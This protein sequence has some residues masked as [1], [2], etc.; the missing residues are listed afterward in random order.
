MK[1]RQKDLRAAI[2]SGVALPLSE[3]RKLVEANRDKMRDFRQISYSIGVYGI[4]GL[5]IEDTTTGQLYA[6]AARTSN[7]FMFHRF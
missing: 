1:V 4:N 2:N 7:V 6:D 5:M 3:A